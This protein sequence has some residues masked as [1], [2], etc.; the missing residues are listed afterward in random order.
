MFVKKTTIVFAVVMIFNFIFI[1]FSNAESNVKDVDSMNYAYNSIANLI[2]QGIMN[3]DSKGSFYPNQTLNKF[4]VVKIVAKISGYDEVILSSAKEGTETKI[5]LT[6]KYKTL[7]GLYEKK[8]KDWDSTAN[9]QISFLLDKGIIKDTDLAKFVIEYTDGEQVVK[10]M[11]KQEIAIW[12]VRIL[13]KESKIAEYKSTFKFTDDNLIDEKNKV[14]IY[15]LKDIGILKGDDKNNF[16]PKS[17]IKKDIFAILLDRTLQAKGGSVETKTQTVTNTTSQP[18]VVSSDNSAYSDKKVKIY[19]GELE[20]LYENN[21]AVKIK[22][23][24]GVS[25]I[26]TLGKNLEVVKQKQKANVVDI[27]Q[28]T[29]IICI[30]RENNIVKIYIT[31]MDEIN[32]VYSDASKEIM[33]QG[34]E[35]IEDNVVLKTNT[36]VNKKVTDGILKQI[37]ISEK[38]EITIQSADGQQTAYKLAENYEINIGNQKYNI[39]DLRLG[40]KVKVTNNGNEAVK[41]SIETQVIQE[42]YKAKID[43]IN[44]LES[45]IRVINTENNSVISKVYIDKNTS[46]YNAEKG[47]IISIDKLE[48][49]KSIFMVLEDQQGIRKLAK[50]ITIL[51]D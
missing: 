27:K 42:N 6:S 2:K 36:D 29:L 5:N 12:I 31:T 50:S 38:S 15:Y 9:M 45:Y 21:Y 19:S 30:E 20:K 46:I 35:I 7:L 16:N 17:V 48:K 49:N 1:G 14:Y 13:G 18:E 40:Q 24:D 44:T 23:N 10:S 11:T 33:S 47:E 32:S 26:A 8:F 28:G 41:L 34:L 22:Q 37:L 4:D 39:Y 3:V 43:Y 25:L 51:K